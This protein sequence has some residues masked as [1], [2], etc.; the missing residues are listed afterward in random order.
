MKPR[1][2]LSDAIIVAVAKLV[3]DAQGERRDPSHSDLDF[4]IARAGLSEADPKNQ[5]KTVG[6]AKSRPL[7]ARS[8]DAAG[9]APSRRTSWE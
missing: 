3:A 1:A 2:P 5:G 4:Q 7:S 9:F 8:A 6:K